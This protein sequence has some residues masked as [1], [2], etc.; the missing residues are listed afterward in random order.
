MWLT[1]TKGSVKDGLDSLFLL[2]I[3]FAQDDI[4]WGRHQFQSETKTLN[5]EEEQQT[6]SSKT[7]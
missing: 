1:V 6:F 4:G 7:L 3:I 5:I 2:L